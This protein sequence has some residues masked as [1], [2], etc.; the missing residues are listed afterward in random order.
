MSNMCCVEKINDLSFFL[1][2]IICLRLENAS[3]RCKMLMWKK[4]FKNIIMISYDKRPAFLVWV[5]KKGWR[6]KL[7][8]SRQPVLFS[9]KPSGWPLQ[10]AVTGTGPVYKQ[11]NINR[12]V[13]TVLLHNGGFSKGCITKRIRKPILF[14]KLHKTQK[15]AWHFY[16]FQLLS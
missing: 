10:L 11:Q 14:R 16:S 5:V 3:W 4:G 2:P 1:F 15:I 12:K 8:G 9:R 13:Q 6:A 7:A